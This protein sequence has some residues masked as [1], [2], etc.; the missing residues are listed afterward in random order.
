MERASKLVSHLIPSKQ[1]D[2]IVHQPCSSTNSKDDIVI[3]SAVRTAIGRSRKGS[4]KDTHPVD[5]L[6]A[7]LEGV[8]EKSGVKKDQVEDIVVG[9][10]L[11]PGGFANN[12]RQASFMAGFPVS[13]SVSTTNR[14]CSSGLQATS[15]VASAISS[16][17]YDI[18]IAAGVESMTTSPMG[19]GSI[20]TL[21]PK[22]KDYQLAR[23]CLT[24]MGITSENVAAKYG[25]TRK[26]QDFLASES[27]RRA[28][29]AIDEGLFKSEIVP[30]STK[31]KGKDG[32]WK[33][34]VVTQDDGPRKGSTPERLAKLRAVFK[35]GGTTTAGNSSQT[36]D[37]AA[38]VLLMKRSKALE[39]KVPI[40][41]V[42]R[43]FTVVGVPP[44]IM[45]IGPAAAIPKVLEKAGLKTSDIDIYEINEAFAS[46]ASY[47]VDKLGIP[48]EKV[49]VN[50]GA[51]AL[52][53]PLGCTGARQIAT[54]LPALKHANKR[55]G[56]VSMC[57]GTGMGAAAVIERE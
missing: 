9:N 7:C 15:I 47:C 29:K 51:I 53:H 41:G 39:L 2:S 25:I 18:G 26:Q 34:I 30:V 23:D 43:A 42:F 8:I 4:F 45:G 22:I 3:V 14:Q 36:S 24:P 12:A 38:A 48:L 52:G 20:G 16:G 57:I 40:M 10:V 11:A 44:S 17:F 35:K 19:A 21:N 32:K 5:L 6:V 46:Q 49:N 13:T 50:G 56:C 55:L 27:H 31:I 37:G 54:I 28:L 33:N 1:N